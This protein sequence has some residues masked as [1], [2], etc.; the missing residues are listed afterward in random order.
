MSRS[1]DFADESAASP[2]FEIF[3]RWRAARVAE[4]GGRR[5]LSL[6]GMPRTAAPRAQKNTLPRW[7]SFDPTSMR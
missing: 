6:T 4:D 1:S 2:W 3:T 5:L 7:P